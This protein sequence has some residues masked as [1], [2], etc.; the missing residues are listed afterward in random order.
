MGGAVTNNL[1][2]L[3]QPAHPLFSKHSSRISAHNSWFVRLEPVVVVQPVDVLRPGDGALVHG[4]LAVVLAQRLE[5]AREL[6][7]A[8]CD[9]VE[10]R[11]AHH[12]SQLG[13]GHL[14][15]GDAQHARVGEARGARHSLEVLVVQRPG[16]TLPKQHLVLHHLARQAPVAVD[17]R[18][19]KFASGG[20][21]TVRLGE[22]ALLVGGEIHHAVADDDVKALV[23][24][25]SLVEKLDVPLHKRHV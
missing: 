22:H 16:Q 11:L 8:V 13:V 6:E 1:E 14:N 18:E 21:H 4:V 15:G 12:L 17:V 24:N 25:A 9:G 20:Q 3:C 23:R 19:V 5:Q 10:A 7:Q 2:V